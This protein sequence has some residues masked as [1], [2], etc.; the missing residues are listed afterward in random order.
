MATGY[1]PA[2]IGGHT[3]ITMH[4]LSSSSTKQ[5]SL[6]NKESERQ[7]KGTVQSSVIDP[8]EVRFIRYVV[9]KE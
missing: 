8:A 2:I 3:P 1:E 7:F 4:V 5:A 9:I 6:E